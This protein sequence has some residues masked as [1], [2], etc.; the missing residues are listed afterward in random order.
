[1]KRV[2]QSPVTTVTNMEPEKMLSASADK[3]GVSSDNSASSSYESLV[4]EESYTD[5][6]GNEE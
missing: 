4:N 5:I 6:W 3:L 1:M 2:Y